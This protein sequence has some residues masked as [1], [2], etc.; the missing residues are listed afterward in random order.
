MT[1]TNVNLFSL[2][3]SSTGNQGVSLWANGPNPSQDAG[4]GN[5]LR[6]KGENPDV[7]KVPQTERSYTKSSASENSTDVAQKTS[8]KVESGKRIVKET[9]GSVSAK[10][11]IAQ[12]LSSGESSED[13]KMMDVEELLSRIGEQM[14]Q[15][16]SQGL[17]VDTQQLLDAMDQLDFTLG[18]LLDSSNVAE[19]F[20]FFGEETQPLELLMDPDFQTL[21][22]ELGSIPREL[23]EQLEITIPE[24]TE[25]LA[26]ALEEVKL[27][28]DL[29]TENRNP[30]P[31]E[32]PVVQ[33]QDVTGEQMVMP[34]QTGQVSY[35]ETPKQQEQQPE[36]MNL[37]GEKEAQM[38]ME[39]D[40][41]TVTV[42]DTEQ[43][44]TETEAEE[45]VKILTENPS[46]ETSSTENET[47]DME[48]F[49][50][51]QENSFEQEGSKEHT[52]VFTHS[53]STVTVAQEGVL[54]EQT[55]KVVDLKNLVSEIVELVKVT[56]TSN[57]V[58]SVEMQL[59]PA[60]LGKV[61]VE[62]AT[63]QGEVTAKISTQT[64]AAKEA[65]EANVQVL[66]DNLEQQGVKVSAIEVTVQ[67]HAFEENLQED[68]SK[69]QQ[70]LAK[71]MQKENRRV[72]VNL[73]E[74][75]LDDLQGLMS[76]EDMVIA[77]MMRDNG[78]VINIGA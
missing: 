31:E 57:Q 37:P 2:M 40:T 65:M 76:E 63:Q 25:L 61:L 56:T 10:E 34:E 58:S 75:T 44:V 53:Q 70:Q 16:I 26:Q 60:N 59:N 17:E 55:V 69:E 13:E 12:K 49:F 15:I 3:S 67:S 38:V 64:Q 62:V 9:D 19:L 78:N 43:E 22:T 1:D 72:N 51:K 7:S 6:Q 32:A 41:K 20:G 68:G 36:I 28:P 42:Q 24:S 11:K 5:L 35:P 54:P 73:N 30:Q 21:L 14:I 52:T 46:E 33:P 29:P 18:D 27:Q 39:A 45:P 71:E 66:R 77:R 8:N 47:S 23:S 50:K 74:M 4:F 48:G